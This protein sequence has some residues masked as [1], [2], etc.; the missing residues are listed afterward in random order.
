MSLQVV[1]AAAHQWPS[2]PT[3]PS[4]SLPLQ[5]A[6]A[7]IATCILEAGEAD[8]ATAGS[9]STLRLL[10]E[11]GHIG[12]VIGK[13]GAVITALRAQVRTVLE[14]GQRRGEAARGAPT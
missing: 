5:E 11:A 1:A 3:P 9:G 8:P 4:F 7:R 12:P 2:R 13:G 6:L 14:A 10:V